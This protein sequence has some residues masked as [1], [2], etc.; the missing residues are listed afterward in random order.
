MRHGPDVFYPG[1][2][3]LSGGQNN[4]PLLKGENDRDQVRFA[5]AIQ[6]AGGP[7]PDVS[8]PVLKN[9]ANLVVA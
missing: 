9:G 2:S 7:D 3:G 1:V 4:M 5:E 6:A 8:L